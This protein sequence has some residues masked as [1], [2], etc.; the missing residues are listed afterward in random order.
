MRHF[1]P[2]AL[3]AVLATAF[4]GQTSCASEG[5]DWLVGVW[6]K[7]H[8]ED[9]SPADTIRFRPDGNFINYGPN[10]QEKLNP[11]F[12]HGGNVYLSIEIPGKGPVALVFKPSVDKKALTFTSPKTLNNAVYEQAPNPPCRS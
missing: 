8:D 6:Q 5:P 10:C 1:K 12:V 9:Q 3:T 7:T 11:Y 4:L 2:V